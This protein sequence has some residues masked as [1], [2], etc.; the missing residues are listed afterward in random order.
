MLTSRML[1]AAC[2]SVLC[3]TPVAAAEPEPS[4]F[5]RRTQDAEVAALLRQIAAE[6]Q[7]QTELLREIAK[8]TAPAP[9][10][11]AWPDPRLLPATQFPDPRL[12]PATP[13]PDPRALPPT[14]FPVDPRLL[15]GSQFPV[16]PKALPATPTF[17]VQPTPRPTARSMAWSKVAR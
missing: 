9:A 1:L 11:Q 8:N 16:D 17:P 4:C 13:F 2:V 3:L 6:Q 7:V 5:H 15:P 10:Q 14:Q 12:L